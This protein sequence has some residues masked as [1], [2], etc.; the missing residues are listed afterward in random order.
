MIAHRKPF[1]RDISIFGQAGGYTFRKLGNHTIQVLLELPGGSV[2][3]SNRLQVELKPMEETPACQEAA[4]FLTRPDVARLLFYRSLGKRR[5][6]IA[7]VEA[8]SKRH[9]TTHWASA[10]SYAIGRAQVREA[11]R[12]K[13]VGARAQHRARGRECLRRALDHPALSAHRTR[14]A[15]GLLNQADV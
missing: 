12:Y 15:E 8:F 3:R 11:C 5:R 4:G 9:E 1:R 2:I 13:S 7:D 6:L 10:L 14:V